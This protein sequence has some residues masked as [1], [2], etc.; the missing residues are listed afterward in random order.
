M[1]SKKKAISNTLAAAVII[2]IIIIAGVSV[3]AV[4]QTSG[5]T[6]TSTV[7][8]TPG[9][10]TTTTVTTST[11]PAQLTPISIALATPAQ[12]VQLPVYVA[13]DQGFFAQNGLQVT[14]DGVQGAPPM[15]AALTSA[16]T[17]FA[18][19]GWTDVVTLFE[20]G[21]PIQSIYAFAYSGAFTL[22]TNP[23]SPYTSLASLQGQNVGVAAPDLTQF[24]VQAELSAHGYNPD[25]FL[26]FVSVGLG[27]SAEAALKAGTV[28]STMQIDPITTSLLLAGNASITF[29]MRNSTVA[30][31]PAPTLVGLTG[32]I[33]NNPTIV[34][35]VVKSLLQA[36]QFIHNNKAGTIQVALKTYQGLSQ[37]VLNSM[38]DTYLPTFPINGTAPLYTYQN[39]WNMDVIGGIVNS[40]QSFQT[41]YTST[42]STSWI[43]QAQAG[44]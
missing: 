35:A 10:S 40:T 27:G 39:A 33:N 42:V 24:M 11:T 38:Y 36:D 43:T 9:A 31:I 2:V 34:K 29:D 18:L 14:L 6:V 3:Y 23:G 30:E 21:E 1:I 22:V 25:T 41:A 12:F 16:S 17:Q 15:F 8:V 28:V 19:F 7:T 37:T 13:I 26:H 32:Y 5:K 4:S 20:R 44:L